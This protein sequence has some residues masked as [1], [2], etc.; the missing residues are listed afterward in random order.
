MGYFFINGIT[1]ECGFDIATVTFDGC[2]ANFSMAKLLGCDIESDV[3]N[4]VFTY[5]GKQVAI[6]PDRW[7][8]EHMLKLVRNTLGDK[9]FQQR[10]RSNIL[11]LHSITGRASRK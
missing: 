6:F 9:T 7:I 3:I 5:N 4:S 10:E 2:S 1:A 11:E 8:E